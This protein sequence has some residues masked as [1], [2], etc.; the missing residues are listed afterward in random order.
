MAKQVHPAPGN[1]EMERMIAPPILTNLTFGGAVLVRESTGMMCSP[2][3]MITCEKCLQNCFCPCCLQMSFAYTDGAYTTGLQVDS[4]PGCLCAKDFWTISKK[5]YT[6]PATADELS[7]RAKKVVE[8]MRAQGKSEAQIAKIYPSKVTL[9]RT[10][11]GNK[12]GCIRHPWGVRLADGTSGLVYKVKNK[13]ACCAAIMECPMYTNCEQ[14]VMKG[15]M[16]MNFKN[17]IYNDKNEPVAYVVQTVPLFPTSCCT[18]DTGPTLQ[19]AIHKHPQY[20]E[21]LTEED[22]ARLSL[23]MFTVV[24]NV[25]GGK[26]GPAKFIGM[27]A[28]GLLVKTG[29]ALGF[30][31]TEVETEYLNLKQVFNGEIANIGDLQ[32]KMRANKY[33]A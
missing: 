33:E 15:N 10:V 30:G 13:P 24:P 28:N 16:C 31:M 8:K 6:V 5:D 17:P 21:E 4:H 23:F 2:A 27:L 1:E 19:M 32:E 14:G 22:I 11:K 18:A 29:W 12:K 3:G 9:A 20:T 26:A 25:P 7:S